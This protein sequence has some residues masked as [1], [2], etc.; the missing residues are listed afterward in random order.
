MISVEADI[1]ALRVLEAGAQRCL[2][3][4]ESALQDNEELIEHSGSIP[5]HEVCIFIFI[6]EVVAGEKR[7]ATRVLGN[8][9][10]IRGY[11]ERT[12]T[13]LHPEDGRFDPTSPT[14]TGSS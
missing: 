12:C 8:D 2:G 14:S 6:L 11:S 5:I 3:G 4:C 10:H 13:Q 1:A 9:R 7:A